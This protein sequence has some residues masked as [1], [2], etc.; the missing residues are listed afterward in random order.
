MGKKSTAL[1]AGTILDSGIRKYRIIQTL[2]QGGFGI[3]YL[4][5]GEIR[6]DNVTTE[7]TF[8]IKEH[9]PAVFCSRQG[10]AV[11]SQAD[12]SDEYHNSLTDF[13]AE[14]KRLQ[15]IGV[16]NA[17]IVKVNE[18]F[19]ANGTAYYVMQHIKGESLTDYVR[20]HG[21]LSFED[22]VNML[23]PIFGAVEHLHRSRINHLDIKPDN[24]MLHDGIDGKTPVLIDFGLSI[25]FKKN[26]DKTSPKGVMGVSEG[27]SPLEQYAGITSFNP[28]TDIYAL[29]ATLLYTLTGTTPKSAAEIK[30]QEVRD[31]LRKTGIPD[32]AIEGIC[33]ALNKSDEDRTGSIADFRRD[34]RLCGGSGQQTK[35]IT[36]AG[37][38][39]KK[40][41][42]M[43]YGIIAAAV[44]AVAALC[45]ALWLHNGRPAE[46]KAAEEQTLPQQYS[47]AAEETTAA[48]GS[49]ATEVQ[50]AAADDVQAEV[51]EEI[52]TP[53]AEETPAAEAT[54]SQTAEVHAAPVA[55]DYRDGSLSLGYATWEGGIRNGKPDGHGR[56][57]F[58]SAHA[59]D[60][61]TSVKASAGDY[62]IATYDNGS[63]IS[64]KLYNADGQLLKTIIP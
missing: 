16:Q 47:P 36:N 21:Q 20:T 42:A 63:L 39:S 19:D 54:V 35:V 14:A 30:L 10:D 1:A 15:A 38:G 56:L 31:T 57:T 33:R 45:I 44:V 3:T 34:L 17:N 13:V 64:G 62:F 37:N 53:A 46:E 24:I 11:V 58:T 60:R 25:H 43:L 49:A 7:G 50:A 27:Y 23:A 32:D 61:S 48:E 40:S 22:A 41:R 8:A 5:S 18:V 29:A 59:V 12:K 6:V 55:D 26:G 51:A 28:A 9:F 4:A 2:G 52:Q